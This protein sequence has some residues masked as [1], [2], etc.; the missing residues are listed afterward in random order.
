MGT[1]GVLIPNQV[2]TGPVLRG[3]VAPVPPLLT[4]SDTATKQIAHNEAKR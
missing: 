3:Q 4:P 2:P 1:I